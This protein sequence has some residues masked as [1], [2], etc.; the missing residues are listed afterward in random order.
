MTGAERTGT[1]DPSEYVAITLTVYVPGWRLGKTAVVA[2][3]TRVCVAT[4]IPCASR[5]TTRFVSI[6]AGSAAGAANVADTPSPDSAA[7]GW[8]GALNGGTK[9][10]GAV[11]PA[12]AL[13]IQVC[14]DDTRVK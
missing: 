9:G 14:T 6:V 12:I 3:G 8:G 13:A 11:V 1:L 7:A 4:A 2:V 10:G 5:I